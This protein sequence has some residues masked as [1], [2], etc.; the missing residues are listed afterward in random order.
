MSQDVEGLPG[1]RCI[2]SL[3][4][5]LL[6]MILEVL[7]DVTSL[8]AAVSC[9][10]FYR[11]F[12]LV[13]KSITAEVLLNQ[14][15]FNDVLPEA[16]MALESALLD[17]HD[18]ESREAISSFVARNLQQ[19]ANPPKNWTLR[20]ALHVNQLHFY[21]DA[22]A[23]KFIDAAFTK[24]PLNQSSQHPV[25]RQEICRIQRALYRFETYC[26]L[27][28]GK[29][30]K[31]VR[32]WWGTENVHPPPI[33]EE[34]KSLFF[35]FFH[36]CEHEQLG[37]IHDFLLRT[38]APAFNEMAER[39]IQWGVAGV[40][41]ID[42]SLES[43]CGQY[44]LSLGVKKL[45]EISFAEGYEEWHRV[46]D[47]G[48]TPSPID[49]LFDGFESHSNDRYSY[50]WLEDLAPEEEK[51]HVKQPFCDDTDPG[52]VDA[53]RWAHLDKPKSNWIYD[54]DNRELREW[55]YVMW[56]RSRLEAA[57]LFQQAREDMPP[58]RDPVLE[59]QEAERELAWLRNSQDEREHVSRRGGSGWWGWGD[60]SRV[61]WDK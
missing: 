16:I 37:C 31:G 18:P 26:N 42:Y 7:P 23:T 33:F 54:E 25:T 10:L 14:I 6:R 46:L 22:L 53:W 44:Y 52:P 49:F 47:A 24:P 45:C 40:D 56:D 3:P 19:R 43:E 17:P 29:V 41:Y 13:E 30:R 21:V 36:P 51:L 5:E 1:P 50:V 20:R 12:L 48:S 2:A 34:Q 8:H 27:F 35:A 15:G 28:R 4:V 55:G 11:A 38:I 60:E 9:S 59:K 32:G 58:T 61:K 39:D 57:G